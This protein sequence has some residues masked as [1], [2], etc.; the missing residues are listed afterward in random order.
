LKADYILGLKEKLRPF[1]V[2]LG[3]RNFFASNDVTLV[4]FRTYELMKVLTLFSPESF[5][6]FPNLVAFVERFERLPAIKAY[7]ESDRFSSLRHARLRET[8]AS[9]LSA[10]GQFVPGQFVPVFLT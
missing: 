1:S 7:M 10:L 3:S 5:A 9:I 2:F 8:E 6:D 4:D